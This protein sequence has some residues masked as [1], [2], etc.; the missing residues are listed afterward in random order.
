MGSQWSGSCPLFWRH[1]IHPSSLFTLQYHWSCT[2]KDLLSPIHKWVLVEAVSSVWNAYP[3]SVYPVASWIFAPKDISGSNLWNPRM[4]PY[5]VLGALQIWL[6]TLKFGDY[7]KWALHGI[8]RMRQKEIWHRRQKA[9]W[10]R[11]QGSRKGSEEVVIGPWRQREMSWPKNIAS[12]KRQNN[13]FFSTTSWGSTGRAHLSF[14]PVR[15][16]L[17]SGLQNCNL[18]CF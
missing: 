6:K 3:T 7:P 11:K 16:L 10:W 9:M 14:C 18:R 2:S 4:L 12:W 17:D 13:E 1:L 8:A 15:H 5:M